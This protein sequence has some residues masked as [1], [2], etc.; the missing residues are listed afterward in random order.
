MTVS[1]HDLDGGE[2]ITYTIVLYEEISATLTLTDTIPPSCTYVPGSAN[3][4][5][6][7]NGT[8][9]FP[10]SAH[11]RW[12][13]IVTG[14]AP[15]TITFQVRV[16]LTTTTLTIVNYALVSRNGD[17]PVTLSAV[18]LLDGLDVY[19]P[20]VSQN[21]GVVLLTADWSEAPYLPYVFRGHR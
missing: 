2:R 4:E 18:S 14:G 21:R 11:I 17:G 9:G 19:L 10:D 5:P 13:G 1:H 3:A 6:G 8:L 16:P 20:F 7:G 12:S 15:L